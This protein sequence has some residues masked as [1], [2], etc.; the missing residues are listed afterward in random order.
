MAKEKGPLKLNVSYKYLECINTDV[1][2]SRYWFGRLCNNFNV[3][4]D[5]ETKMVVC[6]TCT[7]HITSPGDPLDKEF[8]GYPEGWRLM[9]QYVH[10]DGKVYFYGLE[11]EEL[12]NTLP[13]TFVKEKE[14]ILKNK[15][16]IKTRK[17]KEEINKNFVDISKLKKILKTTK[18]PAEQKEIIRKIKL[19]EKGK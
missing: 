6:G 15:N 10:N 3:K 1:N 16:L 17:V 4:V 5:V 8:S 7:A 18:N 9:Q 19:L 2:D 14:K 12:F 11:K 13:P